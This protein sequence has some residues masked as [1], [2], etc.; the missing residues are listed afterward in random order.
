M[1]QLFEAETE[2]FDRLVNQLKSLAKEHAKGAT[3]VWL[4][5]GVPPDGEELEVGVLAASGEVDA[6]AESLQELVAD[7]GA[8]EA[9][10][11]EVRGWTR[12]D[13]EALDWAPLAA[14][15]E[16]VLLWGILP[17]R[18]TRPT[19]GETRRSHSDADETLLDR[20]KR[21]AA[22]LERRPELVREARGEVSKRLATAPPQESKTLTEWLQVLDTMTVPRLRKWLVS[23]SERT[24]RLRQSMP[25][26]LL[27]AGEEQS[28]AQRGSL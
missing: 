12:P 25:F 6:L 27:Q 24:K 9:V 20:A 1:R 15:D 2:R 26:V 8:R 19:G 4:R 16:V 23:R 18:P 22:A 14:T 3:A 28:D 13:L 7:V 11:A 5:E 21:V 10:T 17:E